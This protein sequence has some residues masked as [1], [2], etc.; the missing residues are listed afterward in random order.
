MFGLNIGSYQTAYKHSDY[1][2]VGSPG[3]AIFRDSLSQGFIHSKP[4]HIV[5]WYQYL[6]P[7][8]W[9][10]R[11]SESHGAVLY[12]MEEHDV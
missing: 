8:F 12:V 1:I 4:C 3:E 7:S 11:S 10:N 2:T 6:I 9:F 5:H